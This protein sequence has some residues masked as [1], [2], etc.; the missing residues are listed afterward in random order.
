MKRGVRQQA[1]QLT[2]GPHHTA[3]NVPPVQELIV[4]A[5]H[6]GPLISIR[7]KRAQHA[8]RCR[9]V[10]AL[11]DGDALVL[12]SCGHHTPLARGGMMRLIEHRE[13]KAV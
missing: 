5:E 10:Q 4:H 13:V 6:L 12:H 11:D 9:Q 7:P 3:C 8:R 1:T 2:T